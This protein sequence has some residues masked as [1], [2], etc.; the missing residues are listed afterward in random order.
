MKADRG[1][2]NPDSRRS[3]NLD[4]AEMDP[5]GDRSLERLKKRLAIPIIHRHDEKT[6]S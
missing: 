2:G 4:L 5:F 1:S 3:S 6:F